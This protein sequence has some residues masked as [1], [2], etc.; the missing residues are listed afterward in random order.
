MERW[1][2]PLPDLHTICCE[3][4]TR[5]VLFTI[6]S[7]P[8]VLLSN[9]LKSSNLLL[10][11]SW[12]LSLTSQKPSTGV[13][14]SLSTPFFYEGLGFS[15]IPEFV[16]CVEAGD[17][18]SETCSDL[19][20]CVA[21]GSVEAAAISG[22]VDD[23]AIVTVKNIHAAMVGFANGVCN[24]LPGSPPPALSVIQFDVEYEGDFTVGTKRVSKDPLS[25]LSREDDSAFTDLCTWV[26]RA[27]LAAEAMNITQERAN[28]FPSTHVFGEDNQDIFKHVI[29]TIGNFAE[30]YERTVEPWFPRSQNPLDFINDGSTGLLYA[31]P[32]GDL[33]E[34]VENKNDLELIQPVANGTLEL[35]ASNKFVRCGVVVTNR[36]DFA[37]FNESAMTWQ[38][39]DVDFCRA[40]AAATDARS[41]EIIGV[42]SFEEGFVALANRDIDIYAGAPYT[43]ENDILEPTTG[44]GFSFS[45]CYFYGDPS[46]ALAT[47]EDD[48]QFA[49]FVRWIVWG[50]VCNH[51]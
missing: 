2:F 16:A 32:F 30:F 5:Y 8:L 22:Y 1:M 18:L 40:I 47:R 51:D 11:T 44:N 34:Y 10:D 21:E 17:V 6:V 38:G 45:P 20:I 24:V 41:L 13:G 3:T 39:F 31:F 25:Y 37:S 29:A 48:N 9:D 4:C 12:L 15:G 26:V 27:L 14:F 46:L 7:T 49:D 36:S 33:E 42:Q 43:M 19:R 28:D 35:I 23:V 50:Y